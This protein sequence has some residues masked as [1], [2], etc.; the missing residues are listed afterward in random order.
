MQHLIERL[1]KYSEYRASDKENSISATTIIGPLY[2]GKLALAGTPKNEDLIKL[3]RKR[4]SMIGTA[5]HKWAERALGN[6]PTIVQERYLER[7]I[8]LDGKTYIISGSCDLL[9]QQ[10][11][12]T[13]TIAD[14]KTGYGK[15]RTLDALDKDMK[16][17]SIYRWLFNKE[18][19]INDTGYSLFISQSNNAQDAYP[20]ELMSLDVVEEY[21]ESRLFAI[22]QNEKVD[23]QEGIKYNGC[24]YCSYECTERRV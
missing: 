9:E 11:D 10:A 1:Y 23:C 21:I 16:Q 20:V 17:M 24:M 12:G 8:E 13:W 2:K 19:N 4:S 14:W 3:E 22:E 7:E 15:L 6:D 18:Y 5:V